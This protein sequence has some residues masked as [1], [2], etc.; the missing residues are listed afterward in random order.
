MSQEKQRNP[1]GA[2]EKSESSVGARNQVTT[3]EQRDGRSYGAVEGETMSTLS[4]DGQ[5]WLTKLERVEELSKSNRDIVFNNLGHI[6]NLEMLKDCHRTLDG[7]KAVG[8][9][10]VTKLKYDEGLDENLKN[11]LVRIRRGLY[12]PQAM[13]IV[14]IPK[15]DGSTR[16]L[17]IACY[18]D[19][20]VQTAISRIFNAIYEPLFLE[21]SYGYRPGR[22]AHDA[23]KALHAE[24][25]QNMNGA[26]I[27]IDLC[28]YFNS[29]PQEKLLELLCKKVSDRRFISLLKHM[30]RAPS[31]EKGV[32]KENL[33]GVPQG[34][35]IS[36]ILS[37]IFLH[38][39]IDE[40][41]MSLAPG[42]Q[43]N[44]FK[45]RASVV[46]F[47]DDMIF[48]F[49]DPIEAQA[50][51]NVLPKRLAKF[52]IAI[53]ERKSGMYPSGMAAI[54][55]KAL[56]KKKLPTFKFLGFQ[57]FWG[58]SRKGFYR[59]KQKTRID[60]MRSKLSGLKD[61][62]RKNLNCPN[63]MLV[64]KQVSK[65]VRG[66]M[67]YFGVSDNTSMVW[68]FIKETQVIIYR[69]F[70]RRGGKKGMTWEKLSSILA[71]TGLN[72]KIKIRP[73]YSI[74]SKTQNP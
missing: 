31:I 48:L 34:S 72:P 12:R 37:N 43:I 15:E 11:L 70:N 24:V 27:E 23:I 52:G 54:R 67:E 7:K 41:V 13:R 36:P 60:R 66:W 35:I 8:I 1:D 69:W 64:L 42:G 56:G 26:L 33:T 6:I 9:D 30:L 55:E 38:H 22:S 21:G 5:T 28:K 63:H 16:P 20:I 58:K 57:F 73:L 47:C 68:S 39:A 4:K 51:R 62:L 46:R 50:F 10:G 25:W 53:H 40:W 29:I 65:V 71:A 45:K 2:S 3:G 74:S 32:S 61:F 18:E 14:E 17:A 59:L 49:E 19:K 44:H